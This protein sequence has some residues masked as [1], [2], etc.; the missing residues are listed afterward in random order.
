M[1]RI[2][3][4]LPFF[5]LILV[6]SGCSEAVKAPTTVSLQSRRFGF[7][8][9]VPP[10]GVL[11]GDSG[12]GALQLREGPLK[13]FTVRMSVPTEAPEEEVSLLE[14]PGILRV[15]MRRHDPSDWSPQNYPSFPMP[16]GSVPVLEAVL[17]LHSDIGA[18]ETRD[19]VTGIPLALLDEPAGDH[20][21]VLDFTGVKWSL[22]VDGVLYDND[23]ALGYPVP[24]ENLSWRVNP[25]AVG[26]ASIW[27][28]GLEATRIEG[29]DN[30]DRLG[31]WSSTGIQYWTPPYHNAWVGDV[32]AIQYHGR[33]H[34]FYLFDRR[35]HA[36]KSGRGG[37]YFE[38]LSTGDFK[39]WTEH[40]AATPLEEQWETF[41]T[42]TPFVLH[43]SLFLS[44]GM[45][46]TRIY[47]REET[48]LPEQWDYYDRNGRTGFFSFDDPEGKVPDGATWA[49]CTDG[50]SHFEKSRRIA[51]PCENPSI[52]TDSEGNLRMLANYGSKGTWASEDLAGGWECLDTDFPL[53]GDCTFPFSWGG[54]DYIIGGFV[55][56]WGRPSG[57]EDLPWKDMV[58]AGEDCYN[59][60]SVPSVTVLDDG[61]C[62]MAGWL[63][64]RRWAGALILYELVQLPGGALGSKWMDEVVPAT[65]G[66]TLLSRNMDSAAEF[67]A[68]DKSF[69]LTFE[70]E[71]EGAGGDC[72][73]AFMPGNGGKPCYWKLD[74]GECRAQYGD[75]LDSG[76][77]TLNEGCRI[78]G[79]GNYAVKDG[80]GLGAPFKVRMAVKCDPRFNGSVIDTEI[81]GTRT[82]VSFREGLE[83]GS[84]R[85]ATS[86]C[87]VKDLNISKLID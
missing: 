44:Y 75:A 72:S 46:T 76:E 52:F 32:A 34:L 13:S 86:G 65:S 25:A 36:S 61:R 28:P 31:S 23:F 18:G 50:I 43:D 55:S 62:I 1:G 66:R 3:H 83:V 82:M 2:F 79:A 42:G 14:I 39:S 63:K 56:L 37:H 8:D 74:L 27:V 5:F 9:N 21:V 68:P 45:H 26:K 73:V 64:M 85:F 7:N 53:G 84:L 30:E 33:Y 69:M 4:C 19:L 59:G 51:H 12:E 38:H 20:D 58:A 10:A 22:Y 16:D 87:K 48:S 40:E 54:Y 78:S 11:T 29:A 81:A 57:R 35:G 17:T 15:V 67:P 80:M 70:V 41:G 24:A 60:I 77:K 6:I 49:V 47:P 71:P